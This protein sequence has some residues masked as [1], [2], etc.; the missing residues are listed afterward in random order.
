MVRDEDDDLF[1][2]DEEESIDPGGTRTTVVE[3]SDRSEPDDEPEEQNRLDKKRER[4]TLFKAYQESERRNAELLER[5]TRLESTVPQPQQQQQPD[6]Y[7]VGIYQTIQKDRQLREYAQNLIGNAAR[8]GKQVDPEQMKKL[9]D[10][11]V[12]NDLER[13]QLVAE[14]AARRVAAETNNPRRAAQEVMQAQYNDVRKHP[15]ALN[16]AQARYT[17]AI[18]EGAEDSPATL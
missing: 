17:M 9:D 3:A 15:K 13:Q 4:G 8:E 7:E 16:W 11:I 14:R 5:V 18:A 1:G 6:P 2:L 10:A 12:M